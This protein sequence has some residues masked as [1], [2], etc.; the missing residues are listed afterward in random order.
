MKLS[1][2]G[3]ERNAVNE[4]MSKFVSDSGDITALRNAGY[5]IAERFGVCAALWVEG[6]S[7][8][9]R[10]EVKPDVFLGIDP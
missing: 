9:F 2:T 3:P 5:D 6:P 10:M 4:L 8:R 7:Q 1:Q